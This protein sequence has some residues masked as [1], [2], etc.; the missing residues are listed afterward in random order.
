MSQDPLLYKMTVAPALVAGATLF[1]R[2]FG[3]AAAGLVA[4]LPIVAGPVLWFYALEQGPAYAAEAAVATLLG[5]V[6]LSFFAVAYAWRAWSRG[7]VLSCLILSWLAFA[8]GTIVIN[9]AMHSGMPGL[10]RALGYAVLALFLALRSLPPM[11]PPGPRPA[12]GHWDLPLRMAAAAAMVWALTALAQ[13]LGPVL[14]GLLTPFPVASTVLAVFAH[15]QGSGPAA[16]A[17]LKGLLLALN[18]FAA[19]C[20]VLALTV[21]RMPAATSFTVALAAAMLVQGAV[22]LW[23]RYQRLSAQN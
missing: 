1:G 23:R 2:R 3:D 17:V 4:G 10:G 19:F 16:V 15:R 21:T 22:L 14:G 8:F 18:A 20:A 12:P 13:R 11:D 5:L 9:R 6:S 7:T